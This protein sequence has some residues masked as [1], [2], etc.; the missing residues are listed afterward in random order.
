MGN[1]GAFIRF[2]DR[3]QPKYTKFE[4]VPHPRIQPMAYAGGF[5]RGAGFA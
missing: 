2:D 4:E 3:L 1:K 5:M